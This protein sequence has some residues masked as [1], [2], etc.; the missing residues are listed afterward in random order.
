[1][2]K[3]IDIPENALLTNAELWGKDRLLGSRHL[4]FMSPK[5]HFPKELI[6]LP[7]D[8]YETGKVEL[9]QISKV[10]KNEP[11]ACISFKQIGGLPIAIGIEFV[12]ENVPLPVGVLYEVVLGLRLIP[13]TLVMH[14]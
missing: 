8:I 10:V 13:Y 4:A 5:E 9:L 11:L 14:K 6:F 3:T 12:L 2:K 1:M 7:L